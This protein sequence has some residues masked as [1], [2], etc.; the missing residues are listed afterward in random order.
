MSLLFDMGS[1]IVM[2]P[3][4]Y[5]AVFED[6]GKNFKDYVEMN[7]L[8][9]I[10]DVYFGKNDKVRVPTDLAKSQ[11]MLESIEPGTTHGFMSFLTDVYKRYEIARHYFL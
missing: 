2:T 3:E 10:Y 7:Q 8:R 11:Q 5:K 1:S 9:Y 4:V 6:C